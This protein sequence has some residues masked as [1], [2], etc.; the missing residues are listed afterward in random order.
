MTAPFFSG[1]IIITMDMPIS[2]ILL[3]FAVFLIGLII[4]AI[5]FFRKKRT[6]EVVGISLLIAVLI[7][8]F[9]ESQEVRDI[10]VSFAIVVV[11]IISAAN[12]NESRNIRKESAEKEKRDRKERLL[13][14]IIDW[15]EDIRKISSESIAPSE[16]VLDDP[17]MQIAPQMDFLRLRKSYQDLNTKSVSVK[18]IAKIFGGNLLSAVEKVIQ[19]LDETIETLKGY[20]TS[21]ASKE[22][23]EKIEEYKESLDSCTEE[24]IIEATKI[25]TREIS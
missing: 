24:L 10:L 12:I 7:A 15:A 5:G 14:E 16:I 4:L 8:F 6:V 11:A 13:N 23:S 9:V 21:K 22:N 1:I 3:L 17:T 19:K 20:L 18:A 2:Q 25:K